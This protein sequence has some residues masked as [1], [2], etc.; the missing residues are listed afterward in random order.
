MLQSCTNR[1]IDGSDETKFHFTFYCDD[2]GAAFS[3]S[4][5]PF[6]GRGPG[7]TPQ[8]K[9]LWLLRWQQE[10]AKA[11]A[12]A[13]REAMLHHLCCPGCGRVLCQDCVVSKTTAFGTALDVCRACDARGRRRIGPFKIVAATAPREEE[14]DDA[15]QPFART[16]KTVLR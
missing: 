1:Y 14:A 16:D 5:I 13:N 9:E 7:T 11:F 3:S 15:Q 4:T 6:A 8:E 2:C 12:R 10:H